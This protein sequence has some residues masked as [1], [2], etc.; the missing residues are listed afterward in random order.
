MGPWGCLRAGSP[1]LNETSGIFATGRRWT[2]GFLVLTDM[3]LIFFEPPFS[4][5]LAP[6]PSASERSYLLRPRWPG[7]GGDRAP[8]R[9]RT[10]GRCP[11]E[12]FAEPP[13]GRYGRIPT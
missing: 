8:R 10:I 9:R 4:T 11:P 5:W 7:H 13:G 2:N 6:P 3:R 12:P 1:T